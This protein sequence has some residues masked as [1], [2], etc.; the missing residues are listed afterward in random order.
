MIRIQI[1]FEMKT[2]L[3]LAHGCYVDHGEYRDAISHIDEN[4][5]WIQKAIKSE[6]I[7]NPMITFS[8][9]NGREVSTARIITEWDG[10]YRVVTWNDKGQITS[11]TKNVQMNA[12][13]L[14]KLYIH[15][16]DRQLV[17]ETEIDR[18]GV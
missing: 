15:N 17:Y 9:D 1:D 5:K 14:K 4:V 12:R 18:K 6:A 3:G 2:V 16:A 7:R 8:Y 10:T 13:L 11:D